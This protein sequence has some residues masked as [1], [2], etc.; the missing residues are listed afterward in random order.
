MLFQPG[1][2]GIEVAA[3]TVITI[4]AITPGPTVQLYVYSKV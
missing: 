2:H 4:S 3:G 1:G